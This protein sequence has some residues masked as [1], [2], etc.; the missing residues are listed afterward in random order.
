ML[1]IS[2]RLTIIKHTEIINCKYKIRAEPTPHPNL[3]NIS[4]REGLILFLH[5]CLM[6]LDQS[7]LDVVRHKLIA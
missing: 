4:F 5:F 6:L 7:L 2:L 1:I 3:K